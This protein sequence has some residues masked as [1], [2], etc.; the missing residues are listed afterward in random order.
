MWLFSIYG[1]GKLTFWHP[2]WRHGV[3]RVIRS[4]VLV[5]WMILR[6]LE[7]NG[8]NHTLIVCFCHGLSLKS[9]TSPNWYVNVTFRIISR[10]DYPPWQSLGKPIYSKM[11]S[12][13]L[14]VVT[15][16]PPPPPI[17]PALQRNDEWEWLMLA[18]VRDNKTRK[19]LS[20]P[21]VHE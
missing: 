19:F 3:I 21:F 11:S 20:F 18:I 4:T 2:E 6:R 1:S 8:T 16:L 14:T 9:K 7:S 13:V 12:S 5:L 15:T 10:R 17:P